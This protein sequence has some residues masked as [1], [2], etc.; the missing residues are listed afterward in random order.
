MNYKVMSAEEAAAFVNNGDIVGFSGFTP[1]GCPKEVPTAI[2]KRA[3]AAHAAGKDFKIGMYTGASTGDSLDGALARANAIL[4][5]TPY[6]SSKDLRAR[7]NAQEAH[8]FDMHLSQEAQ[9]LRYGFMEKPKFAVV[10]ACDLT[11]EGEIVPT[12]G[13]GILPTICHLAD[14]IIVELNAAHPKELDRK[15][16][17]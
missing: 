9:E 13:V 5:R 1:A 16:V 10:E 2:A 15:S 11:D 12:S 6:Q 3:E 7:L 4:F 8:Y 14:Y 17:V